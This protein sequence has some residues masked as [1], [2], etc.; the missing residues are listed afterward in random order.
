MIIMYRLI[1]LIVSK[2]GKYRSLFTDS[3]MIGEKI[4]LFFA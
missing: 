1:P 4:M 3:K 2:C